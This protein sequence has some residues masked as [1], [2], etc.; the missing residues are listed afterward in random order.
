DALT[1][2]GDLV[3]YCFA[4]ALPGGRQLPDALLASADLRVEL[5]QTGQAA[6]FLVV[7]SAPIAPLDDGRLPLADERLQGRPPLRGRSIFRH[8]Q[9]QPRLKAGPRQ[10]VADDGLD[11]G[12]PALGL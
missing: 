4:V 8:V 7:G 6:L 9:P 12:V 5:P 3:P 10:V 11:V 2:R 1:Q